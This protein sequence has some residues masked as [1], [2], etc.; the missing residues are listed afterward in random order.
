MPRLCRGR[1]KGLREIGRL[2]LGVIWPLNLSHILNCYIIG[3]LESTCFVS[4]VLIH[5]GFDDPQE[6]L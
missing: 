2:V 3:L 4:R 6:F 5:E 1:E